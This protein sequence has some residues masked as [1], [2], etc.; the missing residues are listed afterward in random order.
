MK[1]RKVMALAAATVLSIGVF[2]HFADAV[3]DREIQE[4][5]DAINDIRSKQS[6]VQDKINNADQQIQQLQTQQKS[7]SAEIKKLDLAV[8]ETSGKIRSL[9]ADIQQTEQAVE[10]LKREIAEVQ[11]RIEKRNE[12]LKERVRSLQESGGVISYLEVLLGSQSFSDFIDRISAVTTIFEADKQII[13]EQQADKALKE[14]KEKELTDKLS[15]L[16][17]DLKELEQLKQTLNEQINQKNQLMANLKQK[18]QEHYEL[19]MELAE[20]QELLKKQEAAVKY[21]LQ[22]LMEK[23]RAEEA[24]KRRAAASHTSSSGSGSI[25]SGGSSSSRSESNVPPVTSGAFMRPANGPV[26]SGFG[27]RSFGGGEFHAGIDIGKRG[28]VV[29]VV[30]AADGYVFRSYFSSSYG[31]VIFITH[32]INGQVYT[33]VYAHLEARLAGEGQ[34]VRKGQVIG[35]MGNTGRSTGPHLHFEL[36]RGQWNPAKSNAVNPLDYINF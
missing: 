32:V 2:P 19:K 20:E 11:A 36:H 3:S 6:A 22:Q 26:T 8:E 30:A 7:L 15:R 33:T 14:K 13:R 5:R 29:P 10:T 17:A 25:Y 4:K 28:A 1:R 24:A 18:E 34:A 27:Y 9:S 12:I 16:Q 31:N 21:Q 35:Y 23:K